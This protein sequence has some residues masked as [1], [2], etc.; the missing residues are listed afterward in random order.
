MIKLPNPP[1]TYLGVVIHQ[2]ADD[3]CFI[4]YGSSKSEIKYGVKE[5]SSEED[6]KTFRMW[7]LPVPSHSFISTYQSGSL[8]SLLKNI[9]RL[10]GEEILD[11]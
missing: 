9:E 2:A 10:E 8:C 1:T 3:G 11:D 6:F 7:K 5:R 4:G